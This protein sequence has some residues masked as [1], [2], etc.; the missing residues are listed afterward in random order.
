MPETPPS[1]CRMQARTQR[2][3]RMMEYRRLGSSGL[4]VPALE[5]RRRH[6][7]R[8]GPAFQR[9]GQQRQCRGTPSCRHLHR[10][11]RQSFRHGRR[12]F[13]RCLRRGARR[14]HQGTA[15][16]RADLHQDVTADGRRSE[17]CRFVALAVDQG[18]RRCPAPPR[19]R[20]HRPDA[21]ARLRC[22][23]AGRRGAFDARYLGARRQAALRRRFQFRRVA[24]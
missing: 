15:Q 17:R 19:H 22:R 16:R 10:G 14:S 18:D 23:H 9:L 20:H 3:V 11:R 13:R 12:L 21:I 1:S 4:K 8:Q 24:A 6:L 2:G 7:R 5:F